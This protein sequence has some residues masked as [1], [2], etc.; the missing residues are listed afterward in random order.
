MPWHH[1]NTDNEVARRVPQV[2]ITEYAVPIHPYIFLGHRFSAWMVFQSTGNQS[3]LQNA[4][5]RTTD[6]T[7]RVKRRTSY[8]MLAAQ[9]ESGWA[10][11]N[12]DVGW[13][14]FEPLPSDAT[15]YWP[16]EVRLA[17]PRRH[18][19]KTTV[20]WRIEYRTEGVRREK[21]AQEQIALIT[22]V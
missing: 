21:L 17:W 22:A 12:T 15:G 3:L 13:K 1:Q 18:R 14:Q 11:L 6:R 20:S 19:S 10:P 2:N 5:P 4:T 16:F 9:Y 7:K 8:C